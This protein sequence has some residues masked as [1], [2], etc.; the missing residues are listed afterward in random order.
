MTDLPPM[1]PSAEKRA[2]EELAEF[3]ADGFFEV[4]PDASDRNTRHI[5][6]LEAAFKAA[7]RD[8]VL[9][10]RKQEQERWGKVLQSDQFQ[11]PDI[12]NFDEESGWLA[13]V[14]TLAALLAPE[15]PK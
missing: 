7:Y 1:V 10:G 2:I 11:N 5:R 15:E 6:R 12:D 4:R 8:G 13:C 14:R 3:A 9:A